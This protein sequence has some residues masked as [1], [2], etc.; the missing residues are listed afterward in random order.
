MGSIIRR[1]ELHDRPVVGVADEQDP[2]MY[3]SNFPVTDDVVVC[4][5]V[6]AQ[7][8]TTDVYDMA[9]TK[10]WMHWRRMKPDDFYQV[11]NRALVSFES[12]KKRLGL[13]MY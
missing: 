1:Y 3:S 4:A 8:Q 10:P 6:N 9:G 12:V 11:A 7:L 13:D 5:M 2:S